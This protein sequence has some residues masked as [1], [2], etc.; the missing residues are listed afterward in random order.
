M[1]DELGY[2]EVYERVRSNEK[3]MDGPGPL[4]LED[5]DEILEAP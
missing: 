1:S 2:R 4:D 3:R 5:E